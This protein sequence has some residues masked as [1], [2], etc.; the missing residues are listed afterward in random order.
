[1][2]KTLKERDIISPGYPMNP[3]AFEIH[4]RELFT[5]GP[6]ELLKLGTLTNSNIK[7]SDVNV[8]KFMKVKAKRTGKKGKGMESPDP[9]M[10]E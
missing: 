5:S 1:M 7:V 4:P 2:R 10:V 3:A 8:K 6:G 9:I